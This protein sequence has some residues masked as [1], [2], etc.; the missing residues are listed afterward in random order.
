[1]LIQFPTHAPTQI[2]APTHRALYAVDSPT[3]DTISTP[4]AQVPK[5]SPIDCTQITKY[6]IFPENLS[7]PV[8]KTALPVLQDRVFVQ[9]GL[10]DSTEIADIVALGPVLNREFYR[11]LL[12]NIIKELYDSRIL[13]FDPLQGLIKLIQSTSPGCLNSD[14]L[15][16]ILSVLRTR[17]EGT[18]G[19]SLEQTYRLTLAVSRVL[20]IMA[21]H[22]VKDLDRVVEHE[23]L[24]IVLSG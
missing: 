5:A 18:H 9:G 13:D 24:P 22:E 1:G 14:D 8:I 6:N 19:Q 23:P 20:D 17:L 7:K 2:A 16:K 4:N 12:S 10:K 3:G 21:N 11:K 15:I